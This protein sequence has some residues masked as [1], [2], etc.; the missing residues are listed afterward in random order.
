MI[1]LKTQILQ[2]TEKDDMLYTNRDD[3]TGK[4]NDRKITNTDDEYKEEKSKIKEDN[5]SVDNYEA[6]DILRDDSNINT[7]KK[8]KH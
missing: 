5:E 4:T 6:S 7:T 3:F 1:I 2:Y 8:D